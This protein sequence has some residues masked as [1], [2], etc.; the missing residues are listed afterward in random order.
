MHLYTAVR[1]ERGRG[2]WAAAVAAHKVEVSLVVGFALV[3]M[4]EIG[5]TAWKLFRTLIAVPRVRVAS[6]E[7]SLGHTGAKKDLVVVP[8]VLTN[9]RVW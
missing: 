3:Q 1:R 4:G 2:E 7:P 9:L 6:V 5:K 8:G